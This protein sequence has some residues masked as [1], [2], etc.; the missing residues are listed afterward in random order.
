M[1][2]Q[3][4]QA[5][6]EFALIGTVFLLF[7]FV[8]MD[9]GRAIYSYLTVSE[10]ARQGAHI[11]EMTDSTDANIR[12]A[13]NS[14]TGFLGDLGT[15]ATIT[16]TPTRSSNQTVSVTVTYQFWMI[17]PLLRQY[18]PITFTSTTVVVAE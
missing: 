4:A 9:G 14:H 18:G 3:D 17:T 2:R 5:M 11:A 8:I 7:F 1:K 6:V 15:S 10:S 13:I 12:S 16:P